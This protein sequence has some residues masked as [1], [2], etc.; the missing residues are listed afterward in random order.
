MNKKITLCF[1]AVLLLITREVYAGGAVAKRRKSQQQR[2]MQQRARGQITAEQRAA[3]QRVMQQGEMQQQAMQEQQQRMQQEARIKAIAAQQ[4]ARRQTNAHLTVRT[5][6]EQKV[7]AQVLANTYR[8]RIE[9]QRR[10]A[11]YESR[12]ID[13]TPIVVKEVAD[14][15]QV[16]ASLDQSGHAW[17]LIIDSEAKEMLVS[18]YIQQYQQQGTIIRKGP[19]HYVGMVDS[20]SQSAPEMLAQPFPKILRIISVMEYDFDNGRNKDVMARE[21]LGEK[22]YHQNKE[23]LQNR[24]F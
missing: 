14:F 22:M 11:A 4:G 2:I 24:N 21:I 10:R 8:S 23:R 13:L 7:Q 18:H 20:M 3:Q 5:Q 12:D 17:A 6:A 19:S 1:A 15:G 16:V 9:Q